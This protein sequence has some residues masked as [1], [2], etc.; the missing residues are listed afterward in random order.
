MASNLSQVFI[1]DALT[2]LS[3]TTFN[4]S[5][6]AADDVGVW[7]LDA[8]AGYISTALY[9]G[10]I[11]SGAATD[12]T[13]ALTL[14]SPLWLVR[15]FQIVQRAVTGNWIASPIIN[16]SQVKRITYTDYTAWAGHKATCVDAT[17]NTAGATDG[18]SYIFK[19]VIRTVP[20]NYTSF[21]N[22]NMGAVTGT[23]NVFPLGGFNTTNH[24]AI[25]MS[26]T[27]ADVDDADAASNLTNVQNAIAAHPLLKDMVSAADVSADIVITS[28]HPGLSF[29]LI[30]FNDSQGTDGVTAAAT[31]EVVG[32]GN[33]WQVADDEARCR[34]RQ[35]NF[36]RMYFPSTIDT[37]TQAGS[38]Y[39][40]ITIE[41]ATPNWPTGA[42]I[43]PAGAINTA[44][45]YYTNA[46]TDPGTT[47]NEF[48]DIFGYTAGTDAVFTW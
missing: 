42:G 41:Y 43:A 19:F 13:D 39:D 9:D 16:S 1:S 45:I 12:N 6:A 26:V 30:V 38:A 24:K 25:N 21:Y 37:Y 10:V 31:G 17:F 40:K 14:A 29:D 34:A 44:T 47:A 7:K 15:D 2:A 35:G 5:D 23:S 46:G 11:E 4:S 48:D 33:D 22:N 3:G 8:T 36:N 32:S 28:L 27:I 20:T 18:D